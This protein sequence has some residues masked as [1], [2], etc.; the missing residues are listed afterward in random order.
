[1]SEQVETEPRRR[2]GW[3]QCS[4]VPLRLRHER[5]I[6][7]NVAARDESNALVNW[8]SNTGADAVDPMF[9]NTQV[10]GATEII[11]LGK[12]HLLYLAGTVALLGLLLPLALGT[13]LHE[14]W[15]QHWI[16][17]DMERDFQFTAGYA[18]VQMDGAQVRMF[19][20]LRVEPSG[21]LYRAGFRTGDIPV[22]Y[23]HSKQREPSGSSRR[24]P[25]HHLVSLKEARRCHTMPM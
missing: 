14:F 22:G 23:A 3:M 9:R 2:I 6:L 12:S 5:P 16:A 7:T 13:E 1:V 18:T 21:R 25:G 17:S 8:R 10:A 11:A 19:T 15:I 24:L 4:G 20:L